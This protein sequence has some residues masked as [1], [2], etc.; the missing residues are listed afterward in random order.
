MARRTENRDVVVVGARCAGAATAMLLARAGHDVLAVDRAT[1][2]SD[3][4]STHGLARGGVVQLQRWGLLDAVLASG[5]PAVREVAFHRDGAA[6]RLTVKERAGVDLLVAPRRHVLDTLLVEAARSAGADVR[7][8]VVAAE[9]LVN[10]TGRVTGVV[11]R[12]RAGR[13]TEVLARWVVGADGLRSWVAR[14]V[15]APVVESFRAD[16]STFCTYVEGH[17]PAYEFHV[18]DQAFAGVF[19]THD[20]AAS[21]WLERPTA[22]LADVRDAGRR[23]LDPWLAQ[24]DAAAPDLARR[25]RAGRVREPLRGTTGLPNHLRVPT[26]PGWALVGDAAYHRD[27]I[28]GHGITDAFRDAELLAVALDS[29]L[30]EGSPECEAAALRRYRQ[31]RDLALRSTFELTRRIA[32][33]PD[34]DRFV[35][36]QVRLSEALETEALD[37]ASRP[38]PFR[39]ATAA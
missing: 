36:L 37:L 17:W 38:V 14:Q 16:T 8:G 19:P 27:P 1:F 11:V 35:D 13:E 22:L 12:D 6:V 31:E 5:A 39:A 3:V 26:G 15:A 23:R 20:G 2:P 10:A 21:I 4:L 33:F 18:S 7:E 9:L 29:V 24:L 28:T 25:V 34:P 30:R 32:A